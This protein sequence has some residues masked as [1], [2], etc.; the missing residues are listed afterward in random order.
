M[1]RSGAYDPPATM[2]S[3]AMRRSGAYDPPATMQSKRAMWRSGA[4]DP[5]ETQ[6]TAAG[7]NSNANTVSAMMPTGIPTSTR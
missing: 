2:Q 4:Y 7:L 3:G 1:R 6:R 5:P